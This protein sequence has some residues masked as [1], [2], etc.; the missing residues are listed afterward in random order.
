MHF[1]LSSDFDLVEERMS[2]VESLI[3]GLLP[4]AEVEQVGSTAIPG[5]LTKGDLDVVVRVAQEDFAD[6]VSILDHVLH[7]SPRNCATADYVEY[8]FASDGQS[9]TSVQFVA[10]GSWHDR[11]FTGLKQALLSD[12]SLVNRYNDLKRLHT[13]SSADVYQAAKC[14]FIDSVLGSD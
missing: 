2:S 8:E 6:G 3:S 13:G 4:R 5:C 14:A 7:R 11:R 1:A 9:T 10:V 12:D